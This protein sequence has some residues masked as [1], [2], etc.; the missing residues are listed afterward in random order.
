MRAKQRKERDI[1]SLSAEMRQ[2]EEQ[3]VILSFSCFFSKASFVPDA[4][5]HYHL[6]F[7][8]Y[9]FKKMQRRSYY[10][11][12]Q[13]I[14]TVTATSSTGPA[15][16]RPVTPVT[17]GN[18]GGQEYPFNQKHIESGIGVV[19]SPVVEMTDMSEKGH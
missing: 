7:Q 15:S 16:S 5:P 4:D 3:Y 19:E 9:D 8:P 6:R 12:T 11:Q 10:P 13:I 17:I 2:M 1:S 18:E 14:S